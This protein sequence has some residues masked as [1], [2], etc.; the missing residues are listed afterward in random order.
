M[1]GL[2]RKHLFKNFWKYN[3]F[4]GMFYCVLGNGNGNSNGNINQSHNIFDKS[5]IFDEII[6]DRYHY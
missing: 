6:V 1:H 3:I 2:S 5:I 4:E